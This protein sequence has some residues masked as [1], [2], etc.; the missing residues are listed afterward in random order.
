MNLKYLRS[1]IAVVSQEPVLFNCSIRE[2]IIY[3]IEEKVEQND[4]VKAARAANIHSFIK[5]LP[6]VIITLFVDVFMIE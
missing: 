4:I 1:F 3:G 5:S 6:Q 2:N